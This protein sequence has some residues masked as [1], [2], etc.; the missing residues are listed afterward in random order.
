MFCPPPPSHDSN[1]DSNDGFLEGEKRSN[2]PDLKRY[3]SLPLSK[4]F[5]IG[6]DIFCVNAIDC[7]SLPSNSDNSVSRSPSLSVS[8]SLAGSIWPGTENRLKNAG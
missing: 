5:R 1:N 6:I 8:M 7:C 3:S 2:L 4:G